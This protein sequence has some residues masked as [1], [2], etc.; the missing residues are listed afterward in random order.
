MYMKKFILPLFAV[1]LLT[2]CSQSETEGE[3]PNTPVPILLN[4]GIEATTRAAIASGGS[5]TVSIGI[6]E[7]NGAVDYAATPTYTPTASVASTS[8]AAAAITLSP[9]CYYNPD[10]N[11]KSNIKGWYPAG[12]LSSGIV[13]L[14]NTDGQTDALLSNAVSG[15]KY[16]AISDALVFEHKT[17]QLNFK[18]V[19][20]TGMAT[21]TQ[22]KSIKVTGSHL[23]TGLNLTKEPTAADAVTWTA[24]DALPVP[25]LIQTA[26]PNE[27][28]AIGDPVM[29][30]PVD[31]NTTVKL[32]IVT[33][34]GS[35]EATFTDMTF[36]TQNSKIEVGK[37][38][39]ITLTFT[40][41][42][43]SL[44]AKITPWATATGSGTVL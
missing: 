8:E 44:T 41:A 22:I 26:I 29:I 12:T 39:T 28:A 42:G 37:A 21:G 2:A 17:A 33:A 13:T 14:N 11:I 43:I 40:Q 36:S 5:A 34:V 19:K 35:A 38:Y 32:T 3:N 9:L 23:P 27:A 6:W 7:K 25:N 15:S 31:D 24:K 1:T 30:K 20:G 4:S 16:G 10:D 18:I